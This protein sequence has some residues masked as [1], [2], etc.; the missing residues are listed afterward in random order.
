MTNL[1]SAFISEKAALRLKGLKR[2]SDGWRI[3]DVFPKD[4][5]IR[6]LNHKPKTLSK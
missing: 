6:K 5:Q 2:K 3:K 1:A 4:G